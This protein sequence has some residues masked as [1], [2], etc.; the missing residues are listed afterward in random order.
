L[1]YRLAYVIVFVV[2]LELVP[3]SG[4]TTILRG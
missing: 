2:S 3:P 4:A 1:F